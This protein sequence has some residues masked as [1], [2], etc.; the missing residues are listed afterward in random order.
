MVYA[1]TQ[2]FTRPPLAGRSVQRAALDSS[3]PLLFLGSMT[4][5]RQQTL[6]VARHQLSVV[7]AP[8]TWSI[9]RLDTLLSNYS[10]VLVSH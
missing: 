3:E 10:F 1:D 9:E 6:R 4:A 7:M 8:P 2:R 5:G